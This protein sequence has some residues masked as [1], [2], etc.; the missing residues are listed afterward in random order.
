MCKKIVFLLALLPSFGFAVPKSISEVMMLSKNARIEASN[1]KSFDGKS[2][3]IQKLEAEINQTL[4]EYETLNPTE[5]SDSEEFVAKFS[6]SLAPV[7]KLATS[8]KPTVRECKKAKYQVEFED[9]NGR[10]ED[11]PLT[12]DAQEALEWVSIFCKS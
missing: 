10:G 5:G 3:K 4:A 7:M 11:A 1:E 12:S 8:K 9:R 2:K 6:F